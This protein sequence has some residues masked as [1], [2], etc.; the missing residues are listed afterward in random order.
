[1]FSYKVL[2]HNMPI[3]YFCCPYIYIYIYTEYIIYIYNV[4]ILKY[5]ITES[6]D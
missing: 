1:M 5:Y 2:Q 4:D 6:I 3:F